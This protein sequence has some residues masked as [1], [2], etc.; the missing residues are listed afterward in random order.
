MELVCSG[1]HHEVGDAAACLAILGGVVRLLHLEFA[2]RVSGRA[3]FRQAPAIQVVARDGNAVNQDFG[4]EQL[5][6]ID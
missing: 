2:D 4:A 3:E 5:P 6:A 1:L